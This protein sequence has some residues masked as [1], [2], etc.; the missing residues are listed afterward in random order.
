MKHYTLTFPMSIHRHLKTTLLLALLLGSSLTALSQELNKK[1]GKPTQEELTMTEYAPDKDARAVEL[2]RSVDVYYSFS[3]GIQVLYDVRCRL[4]V[5]KPEG[6][7]VGD[8]SISLRQGESYRMMREIVTGLK[9]TAYNLEN[10]KVVK[11][12]MEGS[13][14]NEEQVD[15]TEKLVKF[16]V[17]QVRVGTVIEYEYRLESDFFYDL[18]DW[19]AQSDIPVRWTR[20][21]LSVP[22]W[23]RFSIE[24]SGVAHLQYTGEQGN[25]TI[26]GTPLSTEEKTFTGEFLP[27]LKD[28]DFVF[29]A[30]DYGSKVTHELRGVYIPG[31]VHKN[32]STT[33]EDIDKQ[34]KDDEEFG[35]R[36]KKSSPLK[37]E[38]VAAGIPAMADARQRV[39]AVWQMLKSRVRW[40]NYYGFWAK[41][42]SRVLKDGT[43]SN[44]DINFLLINML[45]DAGLEAFPVGL[46]LRN[47]GMLP[48]THASLKYLSTFVVGIQLNDSTVACLDASAQDGYLDVLPAP[49]LVERAR[50]IRKDRP[51]DWLNLRAMS[52]HREVTTIQAT[53]AA[54]GT[55][56]G[57]RVRSCYGQAAASLRRQ[58]RTADDSTEVIH[59]LQDREAIEVSD[60]RLEGRHDFSPTVREMLHFTKQCDTAGDIIYLNPLLFTPQRSNPFKADQRDLP[61]EFPYRQHEQLN[62]QLT[63]PEGWAPEE[64]PK[65]MVIK[66]D[67][68][69]ARI[70][71]QLH[72]RVL[73]ARYQLD[74][75]RTFFYQ[76]Q[77]PDLKAFFDKLVESNKYILTL[78]K[79]P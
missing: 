52:P 54:D 60:Y 22:E 36:I 13:M 61:V 11:T 35:W 40:N 21:Q 12:K 25:M 72:G 7:S 24:Q 74:I 6:R 17:P 29:C 47:R 45:H 31:E 10:G 76:Q 57:Q 51:G 67:G 39:A 71:Y 55:V 70:I 19:H 33:W 66:L 3:N 5:L 30:A 18:H 2:Y 8:I 78:K 41:S 20:Y 64:L 68:I 4:K 28:D 1:W 63:L 46:R 77:Y 56:S 65:P 73:S 58:W 75:S 14:V 16:S 38:I 50:I 53:L 69:T 49:L 34:L 37:S 27:A 9:A 15:K 79:Q 44:A 26:D 59:Q 23:F 43:G 62:V 42:G 48:L 32:Y